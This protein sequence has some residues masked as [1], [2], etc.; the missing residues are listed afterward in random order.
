M[1]KAKEAYL[2]NEIQK[3]RKEVERGR[4]ARNELSTI[5]YKAHSVQYND[6]VKFLRDL[7]RE[8]YQLLSDNKK[9]KQE[10]KTAA[11]LAWSFGILTIGLLIL[12][13]IHF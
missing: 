13:I 12:F 6:P 9:L 1:S 4:S 3:L 8:T 5:I 2:K 10:Y 7:R 11:R